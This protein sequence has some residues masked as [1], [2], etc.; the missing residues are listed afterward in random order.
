MNKK[1]NFKQAIISAVSAAILA[2]L[3]VPQHPHNPTL[4]KILIPL[5]ISALLNIGLAI[6][7]R[8]WNKI[9]IVR[10]L[11]I[12]IVSVMAIIGSVYLLSEYKLQTPIY[13]DRKM[14]VEQVHDNADYDKMLSLYDVHWDEERQIYVRNSSQSWRT[15]KDLIL[16]LRLFV[17]GN[18]MVI[19]FLFF[20]RYK[21]VRR[22]GENIT[23]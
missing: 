6:L 15:P 10:L 5:I 13:P 19:M 9:K 17:M 14:R 22:I 11:P 21:I 2:G 1:L 16:L 20:M 23:V 12:S 18:I 4:G 3:I 8:K 7:Y